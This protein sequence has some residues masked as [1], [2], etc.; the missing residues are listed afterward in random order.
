MTPKTSPE[1]HDRRDVPGSCRARSP[2]LHVGG[3]DRVA[4]AAVAAVAAAVGRRRRS[5]PSAHAASFGLG[6]SRVAAA[7]PH[8]RRNGL[9]DASIRLAG[10]ATGSRRVRRCCARV[11]AARA[12]VAAPAPPWSAD[13]P[14]VSG[15]GPRFVH[16]LN[17]SRR[18]IGRRQSP[19]PIARCCCA[20]SP[21][22]ASR[23]GCRGAGLPRGQS[24][25][26]ILSGGARRP[27]ARRA[28]PRATL[29]GCRELEAEEVVA[30]AV[31]V[32]KG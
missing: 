17:G 24:L 29:H 9:S 3:R 1:G 22:R 19:P 11:E 18:V 32:A 15:G 31:E 28:Y 30:V 20:R 14:V 16:D 5:S 23:R 8:R 12:P 10:V 6:P 2:A 4:S 26:G 27:P 7:A 25:P 21:S 13:P